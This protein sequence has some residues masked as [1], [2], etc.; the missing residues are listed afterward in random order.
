VLLDRELYLPAEWL[1]DRARIRSLGVPDD[2]TFADPDE[3]AIRMLDRTFDAHGHTAW[4]VAGGS[5]TAS[6]RLRTWLQERGQ[7]HVLPVPPETVVP[8]RGGAH[9]PAGRLVAAVPASAWIR[10]EPA[11]QRVSTRTDPDDRWAV[12]RHSDSPPV[13]APA[14]RPGA[15]QGL[16]IRRSPALPTGSGFYQF[17]YSTD[18]GL[19]ELVRA[20]R[21]ATVVRDAV[22]WANENIGL[23]HYQVRR[24]DAWYRHMTLCLLAGAVVATAGLEPSASAPVR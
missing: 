17:R 9:V 18:V 23:D 4:V 14:D 16:L 24:Y 19:V 22:R 21:A 7:P 5:L 3:L 2:V 6:G 1:A 12:I 10:T 8:I 20:A 13:T 11:S 15:E